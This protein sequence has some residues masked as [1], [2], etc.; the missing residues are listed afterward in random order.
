MTETEITKLAKYIKDQDGVFET[1]LTKFL[2]SIQTNQVRPWVLAGSQGMGKDYFLTWLFG[3]P[4][5]DPDRPEWMQLVTTTD[6]VY[7]EP[8]P[9][10]LCR[11]VKIDWGYTELD[12]RAIFSEDAV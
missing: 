12:P 9:D 5:R 6:A 11:L 7:S 4:A 10:W 8:H 1:Q 2:E 3:F